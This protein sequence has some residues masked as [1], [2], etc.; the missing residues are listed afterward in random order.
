MTTDDTPDDT[1]DETTDDT[2]EAPRDETTHGPYPEL[3]RP[4]LAIPAIEEPAEA[5]DHAMRPIA[6]G[7]PP[8]PGLAE[9]RRTDA[10]HPRDDA[11]RVRG[12]IVSESI[13]QHADHAIGSR[14]GPLME[15]AVRVRT[16]DDDLIRASAAA[17]QIETPPGEARAAAAPATRRGRLTARMA[18]GGGL[19]AL[20]FAVGIAEALFAYDGFRELA[21]FRASDPSLLREGA[22]ALSAIVIALLIAIGQKAVGKNLRL[23]HAKEPQ[24]AAEKEPQ[25]TAEQEPQLTAEQEQEPQPTAEKQPQPTAERRRPLLERDLSRAARY[26]AALAVIITGLGLWYGIQSA[27]TTANNAAAARQQA[28]QAA[29][30]RGAAAQRLTENTQPSA[31]EPGVYFLVSASVF[32]L[33]IG[34]AYLLVD[35]AREARERRRRRDA[36]TLEHRDRIRS[37]L[38]EQVGA[39]VAQRAEIAT[40]VANAMRQMHQEAVLHPEVAFLQ[41][42]DEFPHLYG[43]WSPRSGSPFRGMPEVGEA[44]HAQADLTRTAGLTVPDKL[45][46]VDALIA[47]LL[48]RNVAAPKSLP[49]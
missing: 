35:P 19:L 17:E 45:A 14:L 29:G 30:A 3:P 37:E 49:E 22:P 32:L 23:A 13:A 42:A 16:L 26:G 28:N 21:R 47:E 7:T 24:P 27:R 5:P 9:G 25:A 41:R 40:T 33:G 15:R 34:V 46:D 12:T 48:G 39:L 4:L 31:S 8:A 18:A 1:P 44:H 6:D 2:R 11:D 10:V 20:F 38:A 36:A 43:T